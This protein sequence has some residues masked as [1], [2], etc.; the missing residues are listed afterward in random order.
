MESSGSSA[1]GGR[2]LGSNVSSTKTLPVGIWAL[3]LSPVN[4]MRQAG[5]GMKISRSQERLVSAHLGDA[6]LCS[7][8]RRWSLS[9]SLLLTSDVALNKLYNL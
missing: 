1:L 6:G 4:K 2:S 9:P 5:I 7:K 3:P 8:S